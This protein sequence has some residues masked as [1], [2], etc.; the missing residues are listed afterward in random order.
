MSL[1]P[2][3][4]IA[5]ENADVF[6]P[7]IAGVLVA[8]ALENAPFLQSVYTTSFAQYLGN[9]S[10]S[11]Y[12]LHTMVLGTLWTWL[13][14]KA[15]NLTVGWKNGQAGSLE[16]MALVVAGTGPVILWVSDIFSRAWMR[17]VS[18]LLGWWA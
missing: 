7:T 8:F 12:M 17:S 10:F 16:A 3:Q 2:A 9:A 18:N 15:M 5:T 14:P 1:I 11:L 13:A 4:S 6:W